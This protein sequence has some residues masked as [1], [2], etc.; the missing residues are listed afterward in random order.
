MEGTDGQRLWHKIGGEEY[1]VQRWEHGIQDIQLSSS[2]PVLI[3]LYQS[4]TG[5]SFLS[6]SFFK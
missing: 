6:W 2:R 5:F 1:V 3:K 4:G